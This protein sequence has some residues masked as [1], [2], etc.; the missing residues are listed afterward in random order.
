MGLEVAES[1]VFKLAPNTAHSQA[2]RDRRVDFERLQGDAVLLFGIEVLQRAHVVETISKLD[3]DDPDILDHGQHHFPETFRLAGLGGIE[4]E[5]A[6]LG[7]ALDT[8]G[9]FRAEPALDLADAG[10]GV[11]DH[12][13]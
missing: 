3:E 4:L 8:A 7:D 10:V 1:E 12:I 5:A 2:Q 6:Q 11:L 13:V 9:D